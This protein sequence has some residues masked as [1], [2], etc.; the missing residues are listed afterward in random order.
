MQINEAMEIRKANIR[1]LSSIVELH[2]Q[3]WRENYSKVLSAKYLQEE[4]YADRKKVWM[5]RLTK[6]PAN[7]LILIAELDNEFCG[8]VCVYGAKHREFGTIIDNLHVKS[9]SKGKGIGTKLIVAAA[10]WA[11]TN[12]ENDNLYLE[13]LEVNSKAIK[14]YESLGGK[15]IDTAYWHT[16]C[17]NNA[18]ELIYSWG[19]PKKLA[20][21]LL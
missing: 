2:T 17:G 8:F 3:S 13:V 15:K 4:I 12:F 9:N 10:K 18:K 20:D 19:L 1:D 11:V 5:S 6:P 16:P 14:F 7:Q 21:K